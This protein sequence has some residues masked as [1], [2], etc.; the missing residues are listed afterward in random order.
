MR[1]IIFA[2]VTISMLGIT[3]L[4]AYPTD[5]AVYKS[6]IV[7][8]G[9]TRYECKLSTYDTIFVDYTVLSTGTWDQTLDLYDTAETTAAAIKVSTGFPTNVIGNYPLGIETSTG[10]FACIILGPGTPAKVWLRYYIKSR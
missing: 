1:K 10:S 6:T 3:I 2:F 9:K 5:V 8:A 4:Y 7:A